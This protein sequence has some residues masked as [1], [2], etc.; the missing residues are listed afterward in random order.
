MGPGR[1]GMDTD[2]GMTIIM[3]RASTGASGGRM[4]MSSGTMNM[5]IMTTI[6]DGGGTRAE[7]REAG[8]TEAFTDRAEVAD[9]MEVME[10]AVMEEAVAATGDN[11]QSA[12]NL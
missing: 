9:F 5:A 6:L 11:V 2:M 7:A 8:I 12:E 3:G 1:M 4:C 10:V